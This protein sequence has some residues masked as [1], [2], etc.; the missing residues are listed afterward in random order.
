MKTKLSIALAIVAILGFS[1]SSFAQAHKW[2]VH[3][4]RRVEVNNRLKNQN[5]RIDTKVADGKMTTTQAQ[6][7]HK[8]DHEIRHEERDMAKQNGTHITKQEK[9]TLNQQENGV[10]K[11]IKSE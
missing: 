9:K 8:D 2:A 10:S 1:N 5:R 4:P 11:Q 6:A 7:L 3:H